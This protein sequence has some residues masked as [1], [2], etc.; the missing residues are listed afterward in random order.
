MMRVLTAATCG[1]AALALLAGGC[2]EDDNWTEEDA[3]MSDAKVADAGSDAGQDG[4]VDGAPDRGVDR[5]PDAGVTTGRF[6]LK[7]SCRTV[8]VTVLA[9]SLVRVHYIR[10]SGKA[11]PQ[12]GWTTTITSWPTA[13]L[14]FADSGTDYRFK[15]SAL[16]IR[17]AKDDGSVHILDRAGNTLSED[18]PGKCASY[19][20]SLTKRIA[21][22]GSEHFYGF[23]EKTGPLQKRG[24][25][26]V[27]WNTDP[28][29]PKPAYTPT[30]DPIYQSF[31]FVLGLR[32]GRAYGLYLNSTFRTTFD[33]G[34][35]V[36]NE[37]AVTTEGGDLDY[38]FIGGPKME[39]V[40][41]RFAELT[42]TMDLPPLW[43]LGYHQCRWSYY[44]ESK[45]KAVTAEF[46]KRQ[47]PADG[48]WL[49]IDYMNGYRSFTWNSRR[50]PDPKG[51]MSSLNASGFKAVTII[52]P[53][54]KQDSSGGYSAYD[55][56]V[57]GKHFVTL[58]SG[59]LYV[60]KVWPGDAVFPDFSRPATRTWWADLVKKHMASGLS[61][62]WIDMNEPATWYTSG[63]PLDAVFDGEG[64]TTDHRETHNIYA[65]L[66]AKATRDGILAARPNERPFV[67]SRAAFAG[68]QKYS[69]AW[70][71]DQQSDWGHLAVA[72]PMMLN[73]NLSGLSFV[74]SDVGGFSGCKGAEMWSRWI[75]LGAISPFF[76]GHVETNKPDQEP[77]SFGAQAEAISKTHIELRY[78]L[79]P[80]L[81]SLFE[82]ASRDGTP[83]LRPLVFA[84]P[85]DSATY[86]VG[87]QLL[88][89]PSLMA[90]PVSKDKVRARRVYLPAGTWFDYWTDDAVKGGQVASVPAPLERLPLWV[91]QNAILPTWPVQQYVGQTP[92]TTLTLDLYPVN[93]APTHSFSLYEDDGASLSYKTG[94][95]RRT[96]LSLSAQASGATLSVG[97]ATGSYRSRVTTWRVRIHGVTAAPST[98]TVGGKA[99]VKRSSAAELSSNDGFVYHSASRTVHARLPAPAA[100]TSL[101]CAYNA[102]TSLHK[103]VSV[104]FDVALPSGTPAGTIYLASNLYKWVPQG[105]AMT[106]SGNR[107][108]LTLNLQQGMALEFKVTRG[109]WTSV[110][111]R[112][113]CKE[114]LNR[115]VTVKDDGTGA[116]KAAVTVDGW[117]DVNCP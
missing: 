60:G 89:G 27:M 90:A 110:E 77:W 68:I 74:G 12:R 109:A 104:T 73:M 20:L 61:G 34:K 64:T 18:K 14:P 10:S 97:A 21:A 101:R 16:E 56:G 79:L 63:F 100:A 26:L 94:A 112:S 8:R 117:S 116:Q 28:L 2:T 115:L 66:M 54:I 108:T 6:E 29:F 11:H 19:A 55:T 23:G 105:K 43:T 9:P 99:L 7:L 44:P 91:K 75:Q 82:R 78:K 57:S 96:P 22:K 25:K 49:D 51:L 98:V 42:G 67:L 33:V 106:R 32:N 84:Y 17:V 80:Y 39:Q 65:L 92:V 31:P 71:G 83:V 107:A 48:I 102:P 47:I 114:L 45:V 24:Q 87:D 85:F 50:F 113:G 1:A 81:Y 72:A 41:R 59:A 40:V 95:F 93:G 15:T 76:R 46:R 13:K 5:G 52:D 88:V 69:A 86:D 36:T 58:P 53:G 4:A 30:T 3:S 103:P 62:I 37:L 35:A 38:F 70:T 111:K